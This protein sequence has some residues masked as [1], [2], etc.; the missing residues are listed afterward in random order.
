MIDYE[1]YCRIRLLTQQ[2]LTVPSIAAAC[3]LDERTVRHW[4]VQATYRPRQTTRRASKLDPFTGL[5]TRWLAEHAYTATKLLH[6]LREA[7]YT[8]G[9][10]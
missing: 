6:K 3:G 2:A 4:Q 9:Y 7:G 5:L 1:T 10:S 8:G